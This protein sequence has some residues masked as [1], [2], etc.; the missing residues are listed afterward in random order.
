MSSEGTEGASPNAGKIPH[1][2][3]G[4]WA[5]GGHTGSAVV[6]HRT[7]HKPSSW[8]CRGCGQTGGRGGVCVPALKPLL[9]LG[10]S[11]E[12]RPRLPTGPGKS[13][14]PAL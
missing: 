12:E 14:R 7:G 10:R 6:G 13:G 11:T 5:L 9:L 3:K 2:G 4:L 1:L 8:V